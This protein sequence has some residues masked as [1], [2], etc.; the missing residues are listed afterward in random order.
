MHQSQFCLG[1]LHIADED[2]AVVVLV[3]VAHALVIRIIPGVCVVKQ[4]GAK[5]VYA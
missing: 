4:R 5:W 1:S 2:F 3:R